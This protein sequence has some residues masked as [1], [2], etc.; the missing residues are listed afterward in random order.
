MRTAA[1]NAARRR[2]VAAAQPAAR[3]GEAG[4]PPA[5]LPARHP[6]GLYRATVVCA[7]A[8]SIGASIWVAEKGSN[9]G[10]MP[11]SALAAGEHNN[12]ECS[13]CRYTV[14]GSGAAALPLPSDPFQRC[15]VRALRG[16][17]GPLQ[18]WQRAAYE[19]GLRLG[20]RAEWPIVATAY[21]RAEGRSGQVDCRGQRLG[22]HAAASNLIPQGWVVWLP[23]VGLRRVC[24]RGARR[25][26]L[27]AAERRGIWV[28][29]WFETAARARAAGIDGWV[30]TR[31]AVIPPG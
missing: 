29:V 24:D 4:L 26:D 19:R 13:C 17:F 21:W 25:N 8:I 16:D 11:G 5:G 18:P 10:A 31:A 7:L 27:V 2:P 12:T 28:D 1:H 6:D 9:A 20:L 30:R 14:P 3:D 15:A 22:R 23:Q